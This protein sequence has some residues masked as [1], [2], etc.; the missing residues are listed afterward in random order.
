MITTCG[1]NGILLSTCKGNNIT[2]FDSNLQYNKKPSTE[3]LHKLYSVDNV[4]NVVNVSGAGDSFNVGFIAAMINNCSE[5]IC[6]SVG[7][8]SAKA[9][10]TSPSAVPEQ[11]FA[12]DH[13]CWRRS[14]I[15]K[16]I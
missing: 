5:D 4:I 3:V 2:F 6:I 1:S 16:T 14:A 13:E 9:A 7:M 15:Y 12:I 11:Y 10:L 8:E